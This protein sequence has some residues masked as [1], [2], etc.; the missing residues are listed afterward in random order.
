MASR[1]AGKLADFSLLF[2]PLDIELVSVTEFTDEDVEETGLTFVENALLKARHAAAVSGLPALADDSGLVVDCLGGEPGI[3][4]ARYAGEPGSDARNNQKLLEKLSGVEMAD[5]SAH[6][7]CSL[8][9]LASAEDP[10][11]LLA[12][13]R[14][15]GK[16]AEQLAGQRGFGYDPLFLPEGLTGSAAELSSAQKNSLSHRGLA[17]KQLVPAMSGWFGFR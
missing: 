7:H 14:W 17:L 5:R 1:N 16:I 4:S 11:P 3:F 13:G 15:H 8:A 2:G 10:A 12:E 6:F 9:L